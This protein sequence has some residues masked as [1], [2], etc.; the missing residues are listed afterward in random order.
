WITIGAKAYVA[1][2]TGL[3]GADT[4]IGLIRD[5]NVSPYL[6]LAFMMLILIFL[7]TCLDEIG[8]ILLTVPVFL[9][10]V[11]AFG[12]DEIWFGVLYA[13]S[14]QVGYISPPFGYSLFYLKATLPKGV[15]MAEVYR[16]VVPFM[17]LQILA[18][19]ICAAFP[20]LVMW[21][22]RYVG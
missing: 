3:G 10:I 17:G 16:G 13:I 12:F 1:I 14:I 4:L 21:L 19:L 15:G 20:A 11:K 7:G 22:P 2:F 9:P 18:L 5:M 6:V 8:I